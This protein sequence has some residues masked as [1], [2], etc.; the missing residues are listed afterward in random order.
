[1]ADLNASI[2]TD[3][4]KNMWACPNCGKR[5]IDREDFNRHIMTHFE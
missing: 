3:W 1:M 5:F 4:I 2:P